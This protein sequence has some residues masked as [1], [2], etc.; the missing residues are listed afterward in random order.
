MSQDPFEQR[1]RGNRRVRV[2]TAWL[3][4]AAAAGTGIVVAAVSSTGTAQATGTSTVQD[5][6]T[7]GGQGSSGGTSDGGG[8]FSDDDGNGFQAPA[9]PPGRSTGGAGGSHASSG[10]S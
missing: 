8:A 1:R 6:G 5:Q 2:V 10:G 4:A 7:S 3:A 9:Q